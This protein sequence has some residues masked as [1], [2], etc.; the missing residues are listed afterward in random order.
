M[1]KLPENDIE[2]R[3]LYHL[4]HPIDVNN[5]NNEKVIVLDGKPYLRGSKFY[6]AYDKYF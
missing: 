3:S 6:V 4:S 1:K 5:L 2:K